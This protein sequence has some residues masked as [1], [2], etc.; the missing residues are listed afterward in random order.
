MRQHLKQLKTSLAEI[1]DLQRVMALLDWDQQT[2]M[3]PAGSADRGSQLSTMARIQHKR[4]TAPALGR[5]LDKLAVET[6]SL[7]PDSDDASLVRVA[8]KEFEKKTR[9]PSSWVAEFAQLTAAGQAAWMEARRTSN[10]SI[11]QPHLEKIVAMRRSYAT[12]FGPTAHIYDALLDD[13]EP[14]MK[15]AEVQQIFD[16]VRPEQVALVK[17]IASQPAIDTSFLTRDY[18]EQAQ[19]DFG[20][21][22]IQ[23]FGYNFQSGRIDRA[24]HPFCTSF[25]QGD[26][27]ITTRFKTDRFATALFGTMHETGHALYDLGFDPALAHTPLSDGA[28]MAV[29]ESQ[30]RMWE[31]LVG[32]SLPFWKFFYPRLQ[33]A[34]PTQLGDVALEDFYRGI[35]RVSPSYIRVEADEA[36]YNLHIMLRMELEIALIEGKLEV[37]D[38][39][40]AWNQ[41]F[42]EYIGLTPPNDT[43][44]VLQDIHWS[45]GMIGY[46]PTYALGNLV[47]AQLWEKINQDM[48]DLESQI[49]QGQFGPLREWLRQNVHRHGCKFEPQELVRRI[50]G[51]GINPRP[52]L[53]YLTAKYSTIYNLA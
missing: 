49:E 31:N 37:K 46:F 32:R 5:L 52:Y 45:G 24:A 40:A 30:S 12:F 41:R 43:L 22:V 42:E 7:D 53:R 34:F 29:H 47:S 6:T 15:T 16:V 39:P 9:V 3:P 35:N 2:Y 50:T 51:S 17:K 38:L 10:F 13:F 20:A 36:T 23:R 8:K 26:V 27:R 14:G 1:Y 18:P 25:G 21:D 11:F 28:S 44:G 4:W 19:Y 33:Q 48:P